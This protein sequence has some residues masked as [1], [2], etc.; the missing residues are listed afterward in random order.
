LLRKMVFE[1][2]YQPPPCSGGCVSRKMM[3]TACPE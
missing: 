1:Q 2:L 3:A